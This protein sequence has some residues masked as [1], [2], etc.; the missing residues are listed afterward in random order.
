MDAIGPLDVLI[1]DDDRDT[2]DTF[3]Q[4]LRIFGYEP[5]VAYTARDA[6]RLVQD[7]YEPDV[8]LLDIGLPEVDGFTL[9]KELCFALPNRPLVIAVTGYAETASRAKRERFDLH[10]VKPVEPTHL[11]DILSTYAEGR[12]IQRWFGTARPAA[13]GDL[14]KCGAK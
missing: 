5:R 1:V 14:E 11:V 7:G 3:A 9:A 2:A 8:L 13:S 10:F 4:Y 6:G 12:R